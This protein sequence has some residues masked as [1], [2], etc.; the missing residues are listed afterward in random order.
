MLSAHCGL[1]DL[2]TRIHGSAIHGSRDRDTAQVSSST[3]LD[4][5]TWSV[6]TM[7]CSSAFRRKGVLTPLQLRGPQERSVR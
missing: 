6:R 4:I 2:H 3:R 7:E 5:Q 1:R